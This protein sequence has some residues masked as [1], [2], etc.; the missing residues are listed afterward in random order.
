[1]APAPTEINVKTREAD[2]SAAM[3]AAVTGTVAAMARAMPATMTGTV[4][5]AMPRAV[6]AAVAGT[7][8]AMARAMPAPMTGTVAAAM[9]RTV[10]TTMAGAT[11]RITSLQAGWSQNGKTGSDGQESDEFFHD[12]K[13]LGVWVDLLPLQGG[14]F[15]RRRAFRVYSSTLNILRDTQNSRDE[16]T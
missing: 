7:M 14:V 9:A 1:M 6:A 16:M 11:V 12:E 13:K 15:I 10:A 2:M 4:A 3:A 5:A 8:S